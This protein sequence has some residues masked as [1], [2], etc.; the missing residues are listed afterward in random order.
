MCHS[1]FCCPAVP[2]TA[3]VQAAF[4][5]AENGDLNHS[6]ADPWVSRGMPRQND[7]VVFYTI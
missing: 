5:F 3:K 4:D 7:E 2:L 6:A 1:G